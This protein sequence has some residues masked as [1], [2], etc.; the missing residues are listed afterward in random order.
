MEKTLKEKLSFVGQKNSEK[1]TDGKEGPIIT[2]R[3]TG[4]KFFV[5]K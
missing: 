1:W 3:A 4:A 5:S 2:L